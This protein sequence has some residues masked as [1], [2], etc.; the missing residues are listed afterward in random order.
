MT[1]GG[2]KAIAWRTAV[3][4]EYGT[5]CLLQL[6]GCTQVATTADHI[7]PRVTHPELAYDVSNGRPSCEPCNWKRGARPTG[8]RVIDNRVFFDPSLAGRKLSPP[9]SP[10]GREE[11]T[12][13]L[14]NGENR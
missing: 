10:P 1:W 3:L 7:K 6:D 4:N 2:R 5:T 14:E 8:E 13:R 9:V 12:E 11:K